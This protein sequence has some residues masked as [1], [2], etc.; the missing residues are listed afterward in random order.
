MP[1]YNI[2]SRLQQCERVHTN[3]AFTLQQYRLNTH[4]VVTISVCVAIVAHGWFLR[5]RDTFGGS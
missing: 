4:F 2:I 5:I 1:T 3:L